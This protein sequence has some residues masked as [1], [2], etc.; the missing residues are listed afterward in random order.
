MS[1]L[2]FA[3][4]I[5]HFLFPDLFI[6]AMPP[7]IPFHLPLIYFTG[8]IEILLA[9]GLYP[10]VTRKWSSIALA[11]YLVAV[12]PAH[13]YVALNEIEIWGISNKWLLWGRTLFQI[14]L[15]VWAWKLK[16]L[17]I[18]FQLKAPG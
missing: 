2:L 18:K 3:A 6:Q 5:A 9:I 8:V 4:G 17:D 7:Y 15:I 11:A 10:Y 13:F 1:F 16:D 12:L 14:Q